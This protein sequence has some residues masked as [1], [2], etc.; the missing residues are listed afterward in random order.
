M[1]TVECSGTHQSYLIPFPLV[2]EDVFLDASV[3]FDF[4]HGTKEVMATIRGLIG[5]SVDWC[6]YG[7]ILF[8]YIYI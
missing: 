6:G 2:S 5:Q 8:K 7:I 1:N 4:T 3:G